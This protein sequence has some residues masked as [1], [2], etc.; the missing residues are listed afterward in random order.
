M[1]IN[2]LRR[3]SKSCVVAS[4][5]PIVS[6]DW[7]GWDEKF[8]KLKITENR[9]RTESIILIC[10]CLIRRSESKITK[11]FWY[12]GWIKTLFDLW[13]TW[14]NNFIFDSDSI[15]F[16]FEANESQWFILIHFDFIHF[17]KN[18]ME[19][20]IKDRWIVIHSFPNHWSIRFQKRI[21]VNRESSWFEPW[22]KTR[23]SDL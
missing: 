9:A 12:A 21:K 20:K 3:Q 23:F 5:F 4:S 2:Y 17:L 10:K 13:F 22:L 6:F 8:S 18:L 19:S 11:R 16:T 1:T 14:A 15:W 7:F